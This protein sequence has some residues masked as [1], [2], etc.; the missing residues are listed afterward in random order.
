MSQSVFQEMVVA[1]VPARGVERRAGAACV[2]DVRSLG[3]RQFEVAYSVRDEPVPLYGS[4]V[5]THGPA[6]PVR[7]AVIATPGG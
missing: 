6:A 7:N 2:Q 5:Y 1:V 4:V 3:N